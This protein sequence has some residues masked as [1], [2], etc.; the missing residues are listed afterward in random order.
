MVT[1]N[2]FKFIVNFNYIFLQRSKTYTL[3]SS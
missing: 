2:L 1:I 3:L